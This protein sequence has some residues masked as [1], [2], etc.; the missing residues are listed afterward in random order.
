MA[1]PIALA[2]KLCAFAASAIGE[3]KAVGWAERSKGLFEALASGGAAIGAIT[4]A[5]RAPLTKALKTAY[6]ELQAAYDAR[7]RSDRDPGFADAVSVAFAN[8]PQIFESC[9]PL[10]QE[11]AELR[12]D[13]KAIAARIADKAVADQIGDFKPGSVGRSMLTDL[14]VLPYRSLDADPQFMSALQRV[15][16]KEAFEQIGRAHV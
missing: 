10:G 15:N 7:L 14:F 6:T 1:L 4:E 5:E 11:L 9:L 13:P 3:V 12:H 8:F 16:W 2:I